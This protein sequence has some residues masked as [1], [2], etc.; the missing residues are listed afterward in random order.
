MLSRLGVARHPAL[1]RL[2]SYLDRIFLVGTLFVVWVEHGSVFRAAG[3]GFEGF[4]LE[5][6]IEFAALESPAFQG[7]SERLPA[8]RRVP[9]PSRS[10]G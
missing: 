4:A 1:R 6:L 8:S 3:Y 5:A 10:E 9:F 7:F 2:V